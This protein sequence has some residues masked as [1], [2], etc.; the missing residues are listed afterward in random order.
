MPKLTPLLPPDVFTL[1]DA[2]TTTTLTTPATAAFFP[3]FVDDDAQGSWIWWGGTYKRNFFTFLYCPE[4][5]LRL[6]THLFQGE[7]SFLYTERTK[8]KGKKRKFSL[9]VFFF[10]FFFFPTVLKGF[11]FLFSFFKN[12]SKKKPNQTFLF[13]FFP[14]SY[15][16][17]LGNNLYP[18]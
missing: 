7:N 8:K 16:K 5:N 14:L 13:L 2:T 6:P 3:H 10:L 17:V 1:V 18:L 11:P 9:E 4:A 12:E 15:W